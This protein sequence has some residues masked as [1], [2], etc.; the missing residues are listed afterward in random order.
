[1][2]ISFLSILPSKYKWCYLLLVYKVVW[3]QDQEMERFG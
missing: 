2:M 1:M 3:D